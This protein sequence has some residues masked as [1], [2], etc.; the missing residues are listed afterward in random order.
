M[1]FNNQKFYKKTSHVRF[2][3]VLFC[4]LL[5]LVACTSNPTNKGQSATEVTIVHEKEF[6]NI[7]EIIPEGWSVKIS[8]I[9]ALVVIKSDS[10]G[11]CNFVNSDLV[12]ERNK[13]EW[14]KSKTTGKIQYQIE[15][16]FKK[17]LSDLEIEAQKAR[18]DSINNEINSLQHKHNLS[19]LSRKYDDFIPGNNTDKKNIRKYNNE[20]DALMKLYQKLP[21]YSTAK[22]DVYV[23]DNLPQHGSICIQ[24]TEMEARDLRDAIK[25][26]L[27]NSN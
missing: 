1:N 14:I 13:E 7:K 24:D 21:D 16:T 15:Y 3:P 6:S 22:F 12:P 20:K 26:C 23:S 2:I 9:N 27:M 5:F 25:N 10:I 17:K 11:I 8:A 19:H 18:N 4:G